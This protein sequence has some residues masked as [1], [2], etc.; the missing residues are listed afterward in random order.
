[1]SDSPDGILIVEQS[2]YGQGPIF[3]NRA[4]FV[5]GKSTLGFLAMNPFVSRQHAEIRFEDGRYSISDLGS[6]NGTL[7]N[8]ISLK[9]YTP[10]RLVTGDLLTLADDEAE[11]RFHDGS[12]TIPGKMSATDAASDIRLDQGRRQVWVR[13]RRVQ[14]SKKQFD[15]FTILFQNRETVVGKDQIA[16][17]GWPERESGDVSDAD[18]EQCIRRIRQKIEVDPKRPETIITRRGHGYMVR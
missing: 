15:V 7:L 9:P 13:D 4:V 17:H 10:C 18:I 6:T 16:E 1:V 2:V 3:V 11:L 8:G 5:I 12:A 14:L